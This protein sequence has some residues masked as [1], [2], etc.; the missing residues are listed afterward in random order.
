MSDSIRTTRIKTYGPVITQ[1]WPR[2]I[3]FKWVSMSPYDVS[4]VYN[5]LGQNSKKKKKVLFLGKETTCV[6]V[7]RESV[8]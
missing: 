8:G 7:Q 2:S 5:D 4:E 6:H 3:T 1:L